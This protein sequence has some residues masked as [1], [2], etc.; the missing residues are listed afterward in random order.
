MRSTST[1]APAVAP[2][3]SEPES[4]STAPSAEGKAGERRA[5]V[6]RAGLVALGTLASRILGAVRDAVIAASFAVADTDAFWLAFTIPNALRV[7]LGE[8]AVSGAFVPVLTSVRTRDGEQAARDFY[9]KLTGAMLLLLLMVCIAGV[10]LAPALVTLYASGF[11]DDP[12]VFDLTVSLTRWVFPYVGLVGMAALVMGA[13][14]ANK[15]FLAPSFSPALLNVA[16]VVAVFAFEPLAGMIGLPAVGSLAVGALLGGILHFLAQLPSLHAVG[17]MVRPRLDLKDPN[18]RRAFGLLVPLLIGLGVYQLNIIASRQLAS[19]LPLGAISFLFYGQRLVEIPQGMFA[20]AIGSAALPTLAELTERG[21]LAE[22]KKVF[23]YGLRLSLFVA[24]PSTAALAVLAEPAV[25][26][27]FGRGAFDAHSIAETARSLVYLAG[28]IWAVAS[29]RTVVPMFHSMGDTRSPV[30]ASAL[31]VVVFFTVAL[32]TMESMEHAGLALAISLAAVAQLLG[33]LA[34]LRRKIGP[35]G[36]R[37]VATSVLRAAGAATIMGVVVWWLAQGLDWSHGNAVT[38]AL[39][40]GIVSIGLLVYFAAAW[41][42][43]S[44]EAGEVARMLRRR[45]RR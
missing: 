25:A 31:N 16:L 45:I 35:L 1:D 9:G 4:S 18:V 2:P 15:R 30:V 39:F 41:A 29:V 33:L 37:Q 21:D 22:A 34:M 3:A 24:I 14:H 32:A 43:G 8:G 38:I 6:R 44:E 23:R 10:L 5:I 42:L 7:L 40:L 17:Y 20:L 36:L 19:Y 11:R 13:L 26:A 27:L 12:E 28:G